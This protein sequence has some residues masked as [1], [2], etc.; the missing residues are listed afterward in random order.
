MLVLQRSPHIL[1]KVCVKVALP[2]LLSVEMFGVQKENLGAGEHLLGCFHIGDVVLW[3]KSHHKRFNGCSYQ[4]LDSSKALQNPE[5][6]SSGWRRPR[7][8]L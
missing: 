7:W 4:R 2:E 6:H 3:V 5:S 1:V 8:K